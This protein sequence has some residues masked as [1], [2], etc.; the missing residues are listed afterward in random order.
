TYNFTVDNVTANGT[1]Y[2]PTPSSGTVTVS[3]ANVTVSV[4]FAAG[5]DPPAGGHPAD[6]GPRA[7]ATVP[8][9]GSSAM[10]GAGVALLAILLGG[11]LLIWQRRSARSKATVGGTAPQGAPPGTSETSDPASK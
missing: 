2:V 8:T 9:L 4:S 10:I 5:G 7:G 1:V 6:Q 3:G 11:I